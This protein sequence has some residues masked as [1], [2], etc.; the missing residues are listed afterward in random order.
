MDYLYLFFRGACG[1]AI[2][3]AG[4]IFMIVKKRDRVQMNFGICFMTVGLI[5]DSSVL[6]AIFRLP[7]S[8]ANPIAIASVLVLSQAFFEVA[9]YIFECECRPG[10]R[11]HA[12]L[13]GILWAGILCVLPLMDRALALEPAFTDPE[14]DQRL[15]PFHTLTRAALYLWPVII[16]GVVF[17]LSRPTGSVHPET[18]GMRFTRWGIAV[19]AVILILISMSVVLPSP[20][21]YHI[22]NGLLQILMLVWFLFIIRNPEVF[23]TLRLE[24][25]GTCERNLMLKEDETDL[26]SQRLARIVI[27]Q[28]LIFSS[29][30]DIKRLAKAV[31][32]PAYRL[33][34]YFN[35][36]LNMSFS[37]WLNDLRIDRVK[38]HLISE[39]NRTIFEIMM[40]A[41]YSSKTVFNE[42]FSRIVGVSPSE[43]RKN[44]RCEPVEKS[45]NSHA[46]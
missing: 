18:R 22:G 34:N 19:F 43:Y 30:L 25:E 29:E 23:R 37:V 20:V 16:L 1:F 26:I 14:N 46:V 41:G 4:I 35:S 11:R 28:E 10:T 21:L 45:R 6:N 13:A 38:K 5:F 7:E 24:I 12:L 36:C 40:D 42:Q 31:N 17:R 15:A 33:S 8:I 39:P 2:V 9:L 27:N 3:Y 32:V 44:M